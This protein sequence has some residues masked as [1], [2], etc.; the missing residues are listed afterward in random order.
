IV[1]ILLLFSVCNYIL[2]PKNTEGCLMWQSGNV[3]MLHSLSSGQKQSLQWVESVLP[4]G[5]SNLS[6]GRKHSFQWVEA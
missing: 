6:N 3:A 2:W 4:M 5:G 1:I